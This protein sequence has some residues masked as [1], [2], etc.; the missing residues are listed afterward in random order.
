MKRT[1]CANIKTLHHFILHQ[2]DSNWRLDPPKG[3]ESLFSLESESMHLSSNKHYPG[4]FTDYLQKTLI[5]YSKNWQFSS[6]TPY[7]IPYHALYFTIT[8]FLDA[9]LGLYVRTKHVET[10]IISASAF[11]L[12]PTLPDVHHVAIERTSYCRSETD[13]LCPKW[14]KRLSRML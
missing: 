3:S 5:K 14:V 13:G 11:G 9:D 2:D 12:N 1:R 6:L 10:A 7:C 8:V 4:Y